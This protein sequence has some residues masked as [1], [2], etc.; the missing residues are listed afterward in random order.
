MGRHGIRAVTIDCP[1]E[2]VNVSVTDAGLGRTM[3]ASCSSWGWRVAVA[4]PEVVDRVDGL[5]EADW[6]SS[7]RFMTPRRGRPSV[8]NFI[9]LVSWQRMLTVDRR[10][11]GFVRPK[12]AGQ[13]DGD[14]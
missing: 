2:K 6:R 7:C 13:G 12:W 9:R 14:P 5:L 3:S 1:E 11:G 10:E 8:K 4:L